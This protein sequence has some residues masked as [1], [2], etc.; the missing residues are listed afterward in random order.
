MYMPHFLQAW[1]ELNQP[2]HWHISPQFA[3]QRNSSYSALGHFN[4][5]CFFVLLSLCFNG[6]FPDKPGLAG[7]Y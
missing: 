5:F 3:F 6:L 2:N 4:S 1:T 7:V